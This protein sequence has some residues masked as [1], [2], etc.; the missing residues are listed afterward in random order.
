MDDEQKAAIEV[1]EESIQSLQTQVDSWPND[2]DDDYTPEQEAVS[3]ELDEQ[4]KR[5]RS[6]QQ[7]RCYQYARKTK[8]ACGVF[9]C[10]DQFGAVQF[11]YGLVRK[12]DEALILAPDPTTQAQTDES[13]DNTNEECPTA[14]SH[15]DEEEPAESAYSASLIETLTTHKTAA[16]AAELAQNPNAAFAALV[17]TL[18][19]AT[20]HFDIELYSTDSALQI[21]TRKP[22]LAQTDG[23][24]AALYLQEQHQ[25]WLDLL[26]QKADDDEDHEKDYE[27]KLWDWCM[28]R[29]LDTLLR[30]LAFCVATSVNAIETKTDHSHTEPANRLASYLQID[31][32]R[33]YTPTAD[34]FFSRISKAHILEAMQEAGKTVSNAGNLKKA[35]LANLAEREING[36]GWLPKPLRVQVPNKIDEE[37]KS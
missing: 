15:A 16:L 12:E 19:L 3:D 2:V 21:S 5:L 33:W 35:E 14:A 29:D 8:A 10:L 32:T 34:Q 26:P 1:L 27:S 24:P 25:A 23:S 7:R 20:F 22:P 17:H 28:S 36:T 13:A 37:S 31:M 30:L 4:S 9:F 6:L 18:V 11:T